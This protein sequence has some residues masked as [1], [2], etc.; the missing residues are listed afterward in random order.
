MAAAAT[1][2]DIFISYSHT[3]ATWVWDWLRPR[4]EAAGLRVCL[5]RRDFEVGVPSLENM[6]RAVDHSRHTLLV[7][8]PAWVESEWTAFEALLTQTAD[9]AARRRRLIPLLLQPCQPPRRLQMLTYADFTRRDAWDVELLRVIRA[10]RGELHLPALGPRLDRQPRQSLAQRNR[11]RM[12]EKVRTYWIAGVLQRSLAHEV[13]IALDMAERPEAVLRPLDLLV[14][15]PDHGERA[16]PPGTRMIEVFEAMDQALL[17]LGAPGAGKT[18]LLLELAQEL[19]GRAAHDPDHPIPVVFP[20]ST[21]AE[22][23]RPLTDWLVDELVERYYVYPNIAQLWVGD[24]QVLPLLD[25]LDEV[26]PEHRAACVEAINTFRQDHGLLPLVVCSRI[27]DYDAVR[28][29]LRLHGAVVVQPLTRA[30]VDSYLAQIGPPMAAIREAL[31]QDPT[32]WEGLE[33]PLMLTVMTLAYAGA[34]VEGLHTPA[35]PGEWRQRLFATYVERMF[36]RR[37]ART[38]YTR[39]QTERWLAW[40]AWQMTQHSQT[41][42]YLERL[43]PDWL[44]QE[45]RWW[46][47]IGLPVTCG[48][49]VGLLAGLTRGLLAGLHLGLRFGLGVGLGAGL[50]DGLWSGLGVGLGAGLIVRVVVG[51]GATEIRTVEVIH[52]SWSAVGSALPRWLSPMLLTGLG[53]GLFFGLPTGLFFGLPTGLFAGL[54]MGLPIVLSSVWTTL[55]IYGL[56]SGISVGELHTKTVPNEGIRRSARYA[57]YAGLPTGLGLALLAGLLHWLHWELRWGLRW[58]LE[59]GL[60]KVWSFGLG[61]GLFAALLA[62]LHSGGRACLL[63]VVLR[64]RLV[65]NGVAPWRYVA[66]LEYAAER[67]FLRKIGGGYMFIHRQLQEYFAS[68]HTA[69]P[70]AT[71]RHAS[72]E[73]IHHQEVAMHP[74]TSLATALA[75]VPA[76]PCYRP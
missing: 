67:I 40:L 18:T 49:A 59:F 36:Q 2:Y 17:I 31:H 33:T 55:L 35:T 21:W 38:R 39:Q 20:L 57:L 7:L 45:Q 56:P 15:R 3:D 63:H 61:P 13:L 1:P 73:L 32:L 43:Q 50:R 12:L 6:E 65:R 75:T 52:W 47:P 70:D 66:F 42:F 68:L 29:R 24:D 48:L 30:Q 53:V 25:G 44:P 72:K 14:Q 46:F 19:L 60:P 62:A 26:A 27:A 9:P 28:T 71:H 74:L 4:L 54:T 23:R 16:L 37:G 11:H 8:T 22:R 58:G 5:D 10:V 64:L 41:V 51:R 76:P 69:P 34:S